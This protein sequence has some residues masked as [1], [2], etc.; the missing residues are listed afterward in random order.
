MNVNFS[1]FFFFLICLGVVALFLVLGFVVVFQ[2][3]QQETD[4]LRELSIRCEQQLGGELKKRLS[5]FTY[6]MS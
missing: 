3:N 5:L 4:E 1:Q 6:L 2:N